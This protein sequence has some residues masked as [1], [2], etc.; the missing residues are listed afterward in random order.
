MLM[1]VEI[2]KGET[3]LIPEPRVYAAAGLPFPLAGLD[4]RRFEKLIYWIYREEIETGI[5]K[6]KY[7]EIRLMSG[8]R[9]DGKDCVLYKNNIQYG[10]IQCKHSANNTALDMVTFAKEVIKFGLYSLVESRTIKIYD[11]YE[12]YVAASA[13]FQAKTLD[14]IDNYKTSFTGHTDF[15]KWTEQVIKDYQGL[16]HFKFD[17]IETALKANLDKLKILKIDGDEINRRLETDLQSTVVKAFFTV[18]SVVENDALE[19]IKEQL[20]VISGQ[21]VTLDGNTQRIAEAVMPH[22]ERKPFSEVAGYLDRSVTGEVEEIHFY[23]LGETKTLAEIVQKHRKIALLGSGL[24]G[25]STELQQLGYILSNAYPELYIYLIKLD[26]SGEAPI[27]SKIKGIEQIPQK[28]L[29]VLLDGLDEVVPQYRT[30]ARNMIE[31]FVRDHEDCLIVVSCRTNIY[32]TDDENNDVNTL[33]GFESFTL[34]KLTDKEIKKYVNDHLGK[35][36]D[37]F[38][39]C[40]GQYDLEDLLAIPFYLIRFVEQFRLNH[41]ISSNKAALFEGIIRNGI[42]ADVDRLKPTDPLKWETMVYEALVQLSTVLEIMGKNFF[43]HADLQLLF[44]DDE[45]LM[46]VKNTAS[47]IHGNDKAGGAW[48]FLHN[49]FQE[50]LAAQQLSRLSFSGILKAISFQPENKIVK[51]TWFSTVSFLLNTLAETE[52]VRKQLLAW[53]EKENSGQL[54]MIDPGTLKAAYRLDIFKRNYEEQKKK[55]MPFHHQRFNLKFVSRFMQSDPALEFIL[56]ELNSNVSDTLKQALLKIVQFFDLLAAPIHQDQLKTTLLKCISGANDYTR[57]LAT[58]A[59]N[60]LFTVPFAEFDTVF[61]EYKNTADSGVRSSL[62]AMIYKQGFAEQYLEHLLDVLEVIERERNQLNHQ[63]TS[64]NQRYLDEHIWIGRSILQIKSQQAVTTYLDW[65]LKHAATKFFPNQL[66]ESFTF[67]LGLIDGQQQPQLVEKVV[68]IYLETG[69]YNL[70]ERKEFIEFFRKHQQL[71]YVFKKVYAL[72]TPPRYTELQ[73]LAVLVDQSSIDFLIECYKSKA[74]TIHDMQHFQNLLGDDQLALRIYFNMQMNLVEPFPFP[75]APDMARKSFE[76]DTRKVAMFFD[77]ELFR[78]EV[79]KPMIKL[80]KET[81]MYNDLQP[82]R[83]Q[84][85]HDDE[86]FD[87]AFDVLRRDDDWYEINLGIVLKEVD[88]NWPLI[89]I[90]WIYLFAKQQYRWLFTQGQKEY[91]VSWCNSI[92]PTTDFYVDRYYEDRRGHAPKELILVYFVRL[93]NLREFADQFYLDMLYYPESDHALEQLE[94]IEERCSHNQIVTQML[95]NLYQHSLNGIVLDRHLKY[96]RIYKI[97]GAAAGLFELLKSED[98]YNW[99]EVLDAFIELGGDQSTLWELLPHF[100]TDYYHDTVIDRLINFQPQ[101]VEIYLSKLFDKA[102]EERKL[103]L[104][105]IL[106]KLQ[107]RK[108][109]RYYLNYIKVKK[110]VPDYTSPDNA[111]FR[112]YSIRLAD[113]AVAL[114]RLSFNPE[115]KYESINSLHYI[116]ST[117]IQ[118]IYLAPGNQFKMKLLLKLFNTWL[119]LLGRFSPTEENKAMIKDL[120]YLAEGFEHQQELKMSTVISFPEAIQI[121]RELTSGKFKT[122]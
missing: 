57:M 1:A 114:Y 74:L 48:N 55:D 112:V 94:F 117:V 83:T 96:F 18:R 26:V 93:F 38:L 76:R 89:G 86:F 29:V 72:K 7:D 103:S 25:K 19:P 82:I 31:D 39:K 119:K 53:L 61:T 80:G 47:L 36:K 9:D 63:K 78:Q 79:A 54:M 62:F 77:K 43:T 116:S 3:E 85:H 95:S 81:A 106:I 34:Q 51:P 15:K 71:L 4:D 118:N 75:V 52:P 101:A 44:D 37:E 56:Q 98:T 35:D 20:D 24:M 102:T 30:A 122:S 66:K 107:S 88:E 23:I 32:V 16:K 10:V 13:R 70:Q 46:N 73:I 40:I 67:V 65:M 28:S 105:R 2:L 115:V 50:Y 6:D 14:L 113:L 42:K 33:P 108:G 87:F 91:T 97:K 110:T 60:T 45:L 84:N 27:S 17:V 68:E 120:Q 58:N 12:Y 69:P 8:V 49:N 109:F 64:D 92:A 5:W 11:D 100:R 22:P 104:S 21:L 90:Q 121:Y 41:H 99:H 111:L 59:W